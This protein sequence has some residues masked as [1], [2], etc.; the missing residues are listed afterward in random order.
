MSGC[1][2]SNLEADLGRG[3]VHEYPFGKGAG[4]GHRFRTDDRKT[5]SGYVGKKGI[6][7]FGSGR[8][9]LVMG[10]GLVESDEIVFI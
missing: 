6:H 4:K 9:D 1:L 8:Q 3:E 5:G 2:C 7:G 10:N